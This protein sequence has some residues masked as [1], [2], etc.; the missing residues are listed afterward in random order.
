MATSLDL[1]RVKGTAGKVGTPGAPILHFDLL[2]HSSTGKVSGQASIT[3]AI[4]PPGGEIVISN[5]TGQVRKLGFGTG[6]VTQVVALEGTYDQAGPTPT[7]YIILEHF[8]AHFATD[9]KWD[10]RGGFTYG[11]HVVDVVPV[12][13]SEGAVGNPI[14]TLYG[15]VIHDTAATGDLA[16]MTELAARAERHIAQ[17]PE[18]TKALPE[19]KAAIAKAGGKG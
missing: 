12:R 15:V 1:Y 11:S 18:I 17:T 2:V 4:A 5:V 13:G 10:G 7:V 14:H 3:Q 6:P 9:G 8:S 16:K 19:L